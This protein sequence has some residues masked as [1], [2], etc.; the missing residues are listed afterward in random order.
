MSR[1]AV[2]LRPMEE[3]GQGEGEP[4]L[5]RRIGG[6]RSGECQAN[7]ARAASAGLEGHVGKGG[8]EIWIPAHA[9]CGRI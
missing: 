7:E 1:R 2:T 6:L 3:L 5:C 4:E 8:R 9:V